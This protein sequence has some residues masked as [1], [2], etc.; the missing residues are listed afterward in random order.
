MNNFSEIYES[1]KKDLEPQKRSLSE[2]GIILAKIYKLLNNIK[3]V[4]FNPFDNSDSPISI[5]R[6][7]FE[8]NLL[9]INNFQNDQRSYI[10]SSTSLEMAIEEIDMLNEIFK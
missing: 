10:V 7:S 8:R 4:N 5:H 9:D 6:V 3:W 1:V 2:I